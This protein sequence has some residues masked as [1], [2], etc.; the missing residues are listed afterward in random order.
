VSRNW[1]DTGDNDPFA[2][3]RSSSRG[4]KH[5]RRGHRHE[6]KHHLRDVKDMVNGGEDIDEDLMNDL[7]EED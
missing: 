3:G 2:G 6:S 4:R 5:E 7:E 1:K